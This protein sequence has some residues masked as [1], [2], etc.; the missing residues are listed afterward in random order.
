M[1]RNRRY[2]RDRFGRQNLNAM[3]RKLKYRFYN[4]FSSHGLTRR[5]TGNEACSRFSRRTEIQECSRRRSGARNR[6]VLN[7]FEPFVKP[8]CSATLWQ[9]DRIF[10]VKR[11]SEE[12]LARPSNR[13]A[14]SPDRKKGS[15]SVTRESRKKR[16][17]LRFIAFSS[18]F[19]VRS[20]FTPPFFFYSVRLAREPSETFLRRQ[21]GIPRKR[22]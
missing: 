19:A 14:G 15:K 9:S 4:R 22:V 10:F 11:C 16:R 12:P 2:S 6:H 21:V 20:D 18:F 5:W 8:P 13:Q 1:S 7:T 17:G 3:R